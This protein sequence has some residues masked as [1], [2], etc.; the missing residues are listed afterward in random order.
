MGH[1]LRSGTWRPQQNQDGQGQAESRTA[2]AL[3]PTFYVPRSAFVV[4]VRRSRST[5]V[6]RST[7]TFYVGER[8]T[9]NGER[10]RK[11]ERRTTNVNDERR[12]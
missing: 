11:R 3:Q 6:P 8:R 4:H 5:F 2:G 7:F 9:A 1:G 10:E 12:T